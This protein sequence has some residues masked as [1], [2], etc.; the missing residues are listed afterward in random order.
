MKPVLPLDALALPLQGLQVIEASAGTGKT[1]TLATLYLRL[2]LGHG[3]PGGLANGLYPPQI[4]VMTFTEAATAELRSRI[5]ARLAQA[6]AYFAADP[7]AHDM[8]GQ[9]V[10]AA[11]QDLRDAFAPTDRAACAHRLDL[12]AQWMD[13]AAIFTIH[14][15]S[16][17]MLREHAFDSASL[18]QQSR[19]EDSARLRLQVVQDYWRRWYYGMDAAQLAAAGQLGATPDTLVRALKSRWAAMERGPDQA[20]LV[21]PPP[22]AALQAHAQWRAALQGLEDQARA[23]CHGDFIALLEQAIAAK[24]L[25][26]YRKTWPQELAAWAAPPGG[27]TGYAELTGE[28]RKDYRRRIGHFAR[29]TLLEKGWEAGAQLPGSVALQALWDHLEAMPATQ[30]RL[31]DH[32][33][34]ECDQAYRRAK[35]QSAQFDFSDLLQRLY[36]ALQAE[37]GRLADAI[38]AQYPVALVDEFQDTDP[39]QYGALSRIYDR[40]G[41]GP[42]ALVMIGDPKQA[43]YSFR[44]ADLATYLRARDQAEALH[45]LQGNF[46]STPGL[47]QAVNHVFSAAAAPFGDIAFAPVQALRHDLPGFAVGGQPQAAMTVWLQPFAKP[48]RKE[49]HIE[50]LSEGVATQMVALLNTGAATPGEMAV[51][52]RNAQESQ[53]IRRALLRRGVRSVYLSDRDSVFASPEALDLWRVLDAV[54]HPRSVSRARAAMATRLW[55]L[56][57]ETLGTRFQDE[58]TWDAVLAQF[59][60]WQ[61]VWQRQ[62]VLPMLHHWLHDQGIARRMVQEGAG[63]GQDGER[64]L[65]NLLHLGD[66]LQSASMGL[67]GEVALIR[68]LA[69]QILQPDTGGDAAQMRL[70]SDAELV[71]VITMHKS[72]GLQYPLV[73]IP[74]AA[75]YQ[76]AQDGDDD[77]RLAEDVR[78]LYVAL[79][80]A[81]RALWLGVGPVHGDMT[82]SNPQVRSAL[83]RLLRRQTPDDLEDCLAVWQRCPDIS[84]TPAPAPTDTVYLPPP[85]VDH[86]CGAL[87]PGRRLE[88]HW[89]T[90]SFSA[91]TR[92]KATTGPALVASDREER[93]SDAQLDSA[94]AGDSVVAAVSPLQQFPAGSAYGTLLHDLLEWQFARGWPLATAPDGG[95]PGVPALAGSAAAEW[96]QLL[97]RKAQRLRLTDAQRA[98]AERWVAQIASAPLAWP[99]T[100]GRAKPLQLCTLGPTTAWA[101]MAFTVPVQAL[102]AT[103]IDALICQHLHPHLPRK[104]LQAVRLEGMLIGFMDLVLQHEGRYFVLDYKSNRLSDYA[105]DSLRAAILEHRYDV[106]YTLYLLALHRLLRHRLPDYDMDRHL[107]GAIYLFLRGLDAPGRG[108]YF[109]RPPRALIESLDAALGR[110]TAT[111]PE[112]RA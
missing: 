38:R 28:L 70:E 109:D 40:P 92:E 19:V 32:A 112:G 97:E 69:Q 55:G 53:A 52:V 45:T 76:E 10:D 59:Q 1:W 61:E 26:R 91:L 108:V 85:T 11:L 41:P 56:P 75:C 6:A 78:L 99:S 14:G 29:D 36:Y 20:P 90:A 98:L 94:P 44:G 60:Q 21:A 22:D 15:W 105:P 49:L 67:Q 101:E 86:A 23:A 110:H 71:Q 37:D 8:A 57:L 51:L 2:V 72:K 81:E 13:D 106:Q 74:F 77:A 9:P 102:G 43:I 66:L 63:T 88:S 87:V 31:L 17:R 58:P 25:S 80:R 33:A 35:A 96:Q 48:P 42:A 107:G 12:A 3:L 39:W 100:A 34:V 84:V 68:Y 5:R 18:F 89:W 79:T 47:V 95:T 82:G 93:L 65:T 83:S 104:P 62:G 64:R 30:E 73:F 27:W 50:T 4:L 24:S 103:E 16:S 7:L 54:A 111:G 46:R